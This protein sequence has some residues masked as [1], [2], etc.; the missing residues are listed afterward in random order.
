MIQRKR[1]T[2]EFKLDAVSLVIEQSYGCTDAVR[3]LDVNE[4]TLSH[5]V[6]ESRDHGDD[7]FRGHGNL[8]SEQ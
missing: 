5:W 2:K 1:D 4:K 8:T 3:S 6:R 7:A